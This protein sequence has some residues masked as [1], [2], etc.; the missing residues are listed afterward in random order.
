MRMGVYKVSLYDGCLTHCF[1][2]LVCMYM[3]MCVCPLRH[4][5]NIATSMYMYTHIHT[6]PWL[7]MFFMMVVA[8]FINLCMFALHTSFSR[9]IV[10]NSSTLFYLLFVLGRSFLLPQTYNVYTMYNVA[11]LSRPA[12]RIQ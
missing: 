11:A 6:D 10:S 1:I 5:H 2:F 8:I 9:A 7:R 12:Y 4:S 3:C